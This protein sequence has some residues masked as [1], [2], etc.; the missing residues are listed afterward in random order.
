MT[1]IIAIETPYGVEIG[2]DSQA[3]GGD[4][5]QM[6][7]PKVFRNNGAIYGVAGV[8]LLANEMRYADLPEPPKQPANTDK[9]MTKE[10]V[11]ALRVILEATA[12]KRD[13]NDEYELQIIVVANNRA[14]EIGGNTGW[15]RT[16]SGVYA[17]GSGCQFALGA[18]SAGSSLPEAL[19]I[20]AKHDP[21][22][23][24][25]LTVSMASSLLAA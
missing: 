13:D 19:E 5:I 12:L 6:E 24:Y 2:C 14:Y 11:P 9:W 17:I 8:A 20:A 25:E 7:Q 23:G 1:T 4:K 16:T 22:T 10:L 18:I 3:T 15:V 21:Y